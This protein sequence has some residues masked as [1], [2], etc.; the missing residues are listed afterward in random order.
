M[1]TDFRAALDKNGRHFWHPVSPRVQV[2]ANFEQPSLSWSGVGYLDMNWGS[3]P[4]ENGFVHWNWSRATLRNETA[5]LYDLTRR[6]GT[7]L[8]LC[9][10]IGAN[11]NVEA[12]DLPQTCILRQRGFGA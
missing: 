9:L 7:P 8:S 11:G 6:T 3:E 1:L 10:S 12:R 2:E 5:V 4:L